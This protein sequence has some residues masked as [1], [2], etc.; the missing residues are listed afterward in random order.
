[1]KGKPVITLHMEAYLGAP[2]S[3][4]AVTVEG[5]PRITSKITG[6]LHGDVATA[7]ITVNTHPEDPARHARPAHDGGHADPQLVR[8][9]TLSSRRVFRSAERRSAD[10]CRGAFDMLSRLTDRRGR[11]TASTV[12]VAVA[13]QRRSG[14]FD[15]SINHPAIKYLTAD[16]DTVVDRL[17]QKLRDGSAKLVFDEK[18]GY[19]KSVLESAATCRS[20]RR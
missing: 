13:Q 19:L 3:Y 10:R 8:R 14:A 20:N 17:N 2:E 18:T 9:L 6:G 16:T 7:S 1:M 12:A 4:D 15:Q 5:N 11:G